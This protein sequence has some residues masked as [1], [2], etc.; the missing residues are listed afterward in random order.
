MYPVSAKYIELMD[1]DILNAQISMTMDLIRLDMDMQTGYSVTGIDSV[2][3][4]AML[5]VTDQPPI[6]KHLWNAIICGRM[7]PI[8]W[9]TCHTISALQCRWKH[10]M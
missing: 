8:P 6:K 3:Y 7:G 2:D 9:R 1:Q 10:R 4:G 5:E